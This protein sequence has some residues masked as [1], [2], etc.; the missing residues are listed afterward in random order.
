MTNEKL[1][2]PSPVHRRKV[3]KSGVVFSG[4]FGVPSTSYN[5]EIKYHDFV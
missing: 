1:E 3:S 4:S 5:K 2:Q